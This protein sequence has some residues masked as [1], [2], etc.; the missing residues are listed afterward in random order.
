M[1]MKSKTIQYFLTFGLFL[2]MVFL[3]SLE[4]AMAQKVHVLLVWGTNA[5]DTID[6]VNVSRKLIEGK[7]RD[8]GICEPS[9]DNYNLDFI[10][11]FTVLSGNNAHPQRIL[12]Q[13]NRMAQ[14]AG[15][16]DALFVYILCH[17][18]SGPYERG[19]PHNR[20]SI[21]HLLSPY[22]TGGENMDLGRIGI[23]R[24]S[25]L[26][27]MKSRTHRLDV[28]ITDSCSTYQEPPVEISTGTH[29]GRKYTRL[30]HILLNERGTINWNSS[31]PFGGLDGQGETA[32]GAE[33][34][35][36]FSLAFVNVACKD[37]SRNATYTK[38]TFFNDLGALLDESY[39][40]AKDDAF[41]KQSANYSLLFSN[42]DHQSLTE[43]DLYGR[44]VYDYVEQKRYNLSN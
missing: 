35:T 4:P 3:G 22:A 1:K 20:N 18:A 6:C 10:A 44:A 37:M 29:M 40:K 13:C 43:F 34:G 16:N 14:A 39:K 41:E 26:K 15:P 32:I 7:L 8:I 27:A 2:G 12:E 21:I 38:D 33:N 24:Y 9:E 19:L 5:T 31:N 23:R 36:L 28:L 11:S 42:Q 17:G 25:I 30:E